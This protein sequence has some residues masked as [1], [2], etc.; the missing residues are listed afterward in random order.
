MTN[1]DKI[2][3]MANPELDVYLTK[4]WLSWY[5]NNGVYMRATDYEKWLGKEAENYDTNH[6]AN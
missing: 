2:L 5:E 4:A 3:G 1:S 6:S